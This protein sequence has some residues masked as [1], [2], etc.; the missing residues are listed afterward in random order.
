M[1]YTVLP[2]VSGDMEGVHECNVCHQKFNVKS[3]LTRHMKTHEA[4][5]FQCQVC[6][7]TFT[8]KQS[9]DKH[10]KQHLYPVIQLFSE[11]EARLKCTK[12]AEE[13]ASTPNKTND[14]VWLDPKTAEIAAK[15]NGKELWQANIQITFGKYT[16]QSFK[17]LLENDVGWVVWLLHSYRTT[18]EKSASLK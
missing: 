9:L 12:A 4:K 1:G 5:V 7:K 14:P 17:W 8:L 3:N 15:K 11:N 6:S 10:C 18:S 16:G 13:I 2:F